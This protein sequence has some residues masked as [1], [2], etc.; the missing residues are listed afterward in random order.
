M[1]LFTSGTAYNNLVAG[2]ARAF[3]RGWVSEG[4]FVLLFIGSLTLCLGIL[5]AAACG[6]LSVGNLRCKRLGNLIG[7]ASGTVQFIGLGMIYLSYRQMQDPANDLNRLQPMFPSGFFWFC[8]IAALVFFASLIQFLTQRKTPVEEKYAIEYKYRIFLM[9]LPFAALLFVFSYLPLYG[10]RAAF[11]DYEA[12]KDMSWSDFVGFKWFAFLFN[13]PGTQRDIRRVMT[14]TL[15][16]SGLG[17]ATSWVAMAFAI[18]LAEIKNFRYRRFVQTF[19]TVPNFI[20]WVLVYAIAFAI[21]S[22]EGF[23]NSFFNI[24][25]GFTDSGM[26]YNTNYLMGDSHI[27][28]K[29]LFY[30]MWKGLGW[31]AIIYIAAI[32]GID[33]QLYEAATVDGAGRFQKM[34]HITLPGLM[35]TFFVLLLLSI[36]GILSNGMEQ[37]LVFHNASNTGPITVLDL[38]VYQRGIGSGL[39]PLSTMIGML[40]SLISVALLYVANQA[41]RLLR[42]ETII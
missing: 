13:D 38:Y 1:S 12:G 24:I 11:L 29:M 5:V 19:T 10:W 30:G 7:L 42:G 25:A 35:S 22:T 27:W 21:F 17:I 36:A 40:K 16:M 14:N 41:S 26:R 23:V 28:L 3:D 37:Y 31:S 2:A 8:G 39:I 9:F 15:A 32:S 33:Q 18:F 20:S 34:W 6:C 4:S